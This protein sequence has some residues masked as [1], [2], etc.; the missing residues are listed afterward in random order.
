MAV[1]Q[2]GILTWKKISYEIFQKVVTKI[3]KVVTKILESATYYLEAY[4][5]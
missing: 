5:K 3:K 4:G 1:C 2:T